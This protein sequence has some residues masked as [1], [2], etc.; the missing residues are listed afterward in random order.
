M[1]VINYNFEAGKKYIIVFD[2]IEKPKGKYSALEANIMM[3]TTHV[4]EVVD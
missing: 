3:I 4:E 2:V 1:H